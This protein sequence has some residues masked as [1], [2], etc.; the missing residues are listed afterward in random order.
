MML[1]Y[2]EVLRIPN[3]LMSVLAVLVSSVL[4]GFYNPLQILIACLAIFL[5][6]GGG[7]VINDYFDYEAD[8][9]NRPKRALPSGK[10]SK[11][12][13]L[14]YSLILFIIGNTLIFF[15]NFQMLAIALFNTLLLVIYSWKIK[16]IILLGNF[17]VSWLSASIF[18][19][20]SLLSN[21]ITATVF[22][23]FLMAFSSTVGRE[24]TKT[25]EDVEGDRKIR[26][27]TL[28]MIAGKNFAA[29][30]AIIFIIFA[31]LF[32]PIPY[33]FGLLNIKYIYLVAIANLIFI[34]SCFV[35][36]ISPKKSQKMMK[37]AMF[38][39][40]IAFLIGIL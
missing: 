12:S 22:I 15:L 8:R 37:I 25:I 30:I 28:P 16:K 35:V 7:M 6:S 27:R 14:T 40:L 3:A 26:A 32:S 5:I 18:L 24:I 36:F 11:K 17:T 34:S 23:L 10:I 33:I 9:I 29:W 39:A 4:V 19:F 38:I 2:L 20:G 31:I 13:A 21:S 1:S